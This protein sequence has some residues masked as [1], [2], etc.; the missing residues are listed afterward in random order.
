LYS[1]LISARYFLGSGNASGSHVKEHQ[2]Y[3]RIQLPSQPMLLFHAMNTHKQS[4]WK[5]RTGQSLSFIPWRK[6]ET[7]SWSYDVVKDVER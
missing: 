6:E 3:L 5:T 4:R 7:V 2:S 1:L